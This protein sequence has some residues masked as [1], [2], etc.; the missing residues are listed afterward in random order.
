MFICECV[1]K[2]EPAELADRS[3]ICGGLRKI[4]VSGIPLIVL[5]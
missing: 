4:E 2:V 5:A 1:L 3:I